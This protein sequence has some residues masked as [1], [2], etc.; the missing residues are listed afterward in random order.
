ML[1]KVEGKYQNLRI[2]Y[3][4]G[5]HVQFKNG[6]AEVEDK[7]L[8]ERLKKRNDV[9]AFEAEQEENKP[10]SK[11]TKAELLDYAKEH[12]IEVNPDD[13]VDDIRAAIFEAEKEE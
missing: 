10:V 9:K 11:M 4:D 2:N 5:K 8:Q 7:E 12:E 3:K 6:M 1:F 13:K